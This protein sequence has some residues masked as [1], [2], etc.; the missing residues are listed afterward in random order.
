[1]QILTRASR[2][3]ALTETAIF[4][5]IFLFALFA[6]IWGVQTAVANERMQSAV[7]YSGMI[8]DQVQPYMEY[9]LFAMYNNL[10]NNVTVGTQPCQTPPPASLTDSPPY[11]GPS[12]APFWRV[13]NVTSS[14]S[15]G[16]TQIT[17]G[18]LDS[19]ALLLHDF[20]QMSATTSV[21]PY[22]TATLGRSLTTL[23]ATQ[24]FTAPPDIS[25]MMHCYPELNAAITQSLRPQTAPNVTV[26]PTPL[27]PDPAT[28]SLTVACSDIPTG[29]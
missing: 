5:P 9:S 22:I 14:C 24:N 23:T 19:P 16:M 8:S 17:G 12:A 3:Q 2:G 20:S 11:P 1:M 4:L 26:L 7:R 29:D 6:A 10:G 18:G 28:N 25:T 21:P 15:G 13:S 27:P